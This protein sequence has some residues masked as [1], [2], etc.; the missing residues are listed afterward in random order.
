MEVQMGTNDLLPPPATSP[1]PAAPPVS[2]RPLPPP[3]TTAAPVIPAPAVPPS[4]LVFEPVPEPAVAEPVTA[5][6]PGPEPL[7]TIK[8]W[9]L[10]LVV[11]VVLLAL[12]YVAGII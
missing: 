8:V 4:P 7:F 5:V 9:Q 11:F 2:S 12:L 3:A 1:S 6:A 10:G